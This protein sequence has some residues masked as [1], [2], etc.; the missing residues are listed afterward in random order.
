V[1][2]GFYFAALAPKGGDARA[3]FAGGGG[4]LA[5]FLNAM[6]HLGG[7]LGPIL[8]EFPNTFSLARFQR[9]G[10]VSAEAAAGVPFSRW[11]CGAAWRME[12]FD[13]TLS[14]MKMARTATLFP[15]A[16]HLPK[17]TTDFMFIR[18]AGTSR[19]KPAAKVAEARTKEIGKWA[20]RIAKALPAEGMAFGYFSNNYTGH[21]PDAARE[22]MRSMKAIGERGRGA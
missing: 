15:G 3:G 18:W 8:F 19:D 7:K 2:D 10:G 17:A 9:A 13:D 22:L 14:E 6:E 21:A 16:S 4:E 1:P 5:Q 12:T 20:E 11:R